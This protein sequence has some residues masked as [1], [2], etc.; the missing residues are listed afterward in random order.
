VRERERKLRKRKAFELLS[1]SVRGGIFLYCSRRYKRLFKYKWLLKMVLKRVGYL[2]RLP[3]KR[4]QDG[5]VV[6]HK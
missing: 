5:M 6:K 4:D 3:S 1:A 2:E